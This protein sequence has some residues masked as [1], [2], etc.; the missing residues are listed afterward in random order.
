MRATC[1]VPS[2]DVLLG[3]KSDNTI[4]YLSKRLLECGVTFSRINTIQNA[5]N[6]ILSEIENSKDSLIVILGEKSS[7]KN[8]N[9][10]KAIASFYDTELVQNN[11][12]VNAVQN[13]YKKQGQPV[14]LEHENEY[15]LPENSRVIINPNGPMQGFFIK[16]SAKSILFLPNDL[17][18]VSK[19]YD[20]AVLP[21][22]L[23]N[24]SLEYLAYNIKTFGIVEKDILS[25]LKDLLSNK[26]KILITTYPQDLEV[27]IVV[28]YNKSLSGEIIEKFI[29]KIYERLNKYIYANED[30]S[31][32][33]SALDLLKLSNKKIAI[34]ECITG[35]NVMAGLLACDSDASKYIVD[36][37]VCNNDKA[38]HDRAKVDNGVLNNYA[39]N[40]PEMAYEIGAGMLEVTD[41]DLVLVTA[42]DTDFNPRNKSYSIAVGDRDGIHVY[43]NTFIGTHE[44]IIESVS[45][46]SMFYLIK[47]LKQNDLSFLR[48]SI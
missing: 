34:A 4:Q 15:F 32:Y 14:L 29:Q 3:K 17:L 46:T 10:K 44:Q 42:G 6:E 24:F 47:K 45:K 8:V 38:K 37:V 31:I 9:I 2:S 13:Y 41:A 23:E 21:V 5:P 19:M 40:S 35:G 30:V 22:L 33:K 27:G 28:R 26:Y 18:M 39:P 11:V 20:Y 1:I 43:K 48:D 16:N 12:A 7:V 36:G 25:L